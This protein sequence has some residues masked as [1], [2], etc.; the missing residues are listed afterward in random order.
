M[1]AFPYSIALELNSVLILW[2]G[3]SIWQR[4]RRA[5]GGR[6]FAALIAGVL[7]WSLGELLYV[8]GL[9]DPW[10]H[11]VV[12]YIGVFSVGPFF[13]G[14]A[15]HA[16]AVPLA[17]RVPWFPLALWAPGVFVYA[18]LFLGPWSG[19]FLS[20]RT[21]EVIRGPLFWIYNFYAYALVLAS[22]SLLVVAARRWPRKGLVRRVGALTLSVLVPLAG[23]IL[24]VHMSA[25]I[26]F[27]P[28]PLLISAAAIALRAAVFRGGLLDVLPIDDQSL[29]EH[30]PVGLLLADRQGGVIEANPAALDWLGMS[31]EQALGRSLEAL[32][33]TLPPG[34]GVH[35]TRFD[36]HRRQELACAVLTEENAAPAMRQVALG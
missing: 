29:V 36:L 20:F 4:D 22:I 11:A 5:P 13:V 33:A 6:W 30:L 15:A 1:E 24:Y 17:R 23:N 35:T 8:R 19:L 26:P 18:F 28:T 12:V 34:V 10:Q 31:R 14:L 27:D 21:N 25:L 9:L 32:L 7:I 3:L 16:A 2:I